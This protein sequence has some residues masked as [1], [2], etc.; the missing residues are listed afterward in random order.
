MTT[1]R[2]STL[3]RGEFPSDPSRQKELVKRLFLA[4]VNLEGILDQGLANKATAEGTA[5]KEWVPVHPNP[6][7]KYGTRVVAVCERSDIELELVAWKL[8][9]RPPLVIVPPPQH[10][11]ES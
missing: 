6:A 10:R 9:V 1:Q 11:M 3:K 5:A 8:L 7:T 2:K 4:M